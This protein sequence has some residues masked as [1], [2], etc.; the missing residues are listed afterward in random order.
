[1]RRKPHTSGQVAPVASALPAVRLGRIVRWD[2]ER[3]PL[4]DYDG[5]PGGPLVARATVPLDAASAR[6]AAQA[7]RPV[8]LVFEDGDPSLP[9]IV[10]LVEPAPG[11]RLLE[12]VLAQ[13]Q[14]EADARVDGRRVV[15]EGEEE[16]VLRCGKVVVRGADVLQVSSGLHRIKGGA[17]EIN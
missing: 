4:V 7:R 9:I 11:A 2:G 17:V 12:E 16:V 15:L 10:G 3:G 13:P 8:L 1:M 6:A 14:P 5:N